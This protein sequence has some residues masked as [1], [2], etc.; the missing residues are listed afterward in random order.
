MLRSFSAF[1]TCSTAGSD[2]AD[3]ELACLM[4]RQSVGGP[5]TKTCPSSS[6]LPC[7]DATRDQLLIFTDPK[8]GS[9]SLQHSLQNSLPFFPPHVPELMKEYP[10]H[11]KCHRADIATDFLTKVEKNSTV[12]IVKSVRSVLE[13][14]ISAFFQTLCRD[15]D[16]NHCFDCKVC[17]DDPTATATSS[18]IEELVEN[19]KAHCS[20]LFS[21]SGRQSTAQFSAIE[22]FE[23]AT[24]TDIGP[25][26]FDHVG[27]SKFD[28]AEGRLLVQSS[29][30]GLKINT[31]IVRLEDINRWPSIM[32]PMFPLY[33]NR[34]SNIG[35]E[36]WYAD[37][38]HVFK[39]SLYASLNAT[40]LQE[41][42]NL[43]DEMS[44]YTSEEQDAIAR[45][46]LG[47]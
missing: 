28:H 1:L 25:S 14:Q 39:G 7:F 21:S 44:F 47:L 32:K 5:V 22:E 9:E 19:F 31:V 23:K 42:F 10:L 3:G 46:S 11:M 45:R 15:E 38:Y 36:K 8:T 13:Q 29:V 18:A 41:V 6:D 37:I 34:S 33:N 26:K 2:H 30:N 40:F 20:W 27:P 12:W 4:Q 17:R 16:K 35:S 24:G 43:C